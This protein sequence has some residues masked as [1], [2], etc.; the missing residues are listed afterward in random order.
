MVYGMA[1]SVDCFD[2]CAL[3]SE[4]VSIVDGKVVVAGGVFVDFC[5]GT[6]GEKRFYA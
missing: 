6:K 1:W 3:D 4:D 5:F 2:G